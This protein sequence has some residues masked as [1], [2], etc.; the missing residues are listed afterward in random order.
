MKKLD[1]TGWLGILAC[2]VLLIGGTI[3]SGKQ[4]IAE[5]ERLAAAQA[6][7]DAEKAEKEAAIASDAPVPAAA[8]GD[9]AATP[10][11]TAAAQPAAVAA[12]EVQLSTEKF[13]LT[14]TNQGG[15]IKSAELLEHKRSLDSEGEYVSLNASRPAPV[16]ALSSEPEKLDTSLWSIKSQSDASVTFAADTPDGLHIEKTFSIPDH[17]R[18]Y[19]VDMDITIRNDSGNPIDID[20]SSA[21]YVYAGGAEPMEWNEWS[22]QMGLFIK[23]QKSQ[24]FK[25]TVDYFGGKGKVMGI[26]GHSYKPHAILPKKEVADNLI[27][28]GVNNQFFATIIEA[29]EPA[30]GQV[31][32]ADYKAT[33][34]GDETKSRQKKIR[35]CEL[36]VSLPEA[37]M[38]PGG[39][40]TISYSV[41]MGP[42]EEAILKDPK[43]VE[44]G[45]VMNYSAIPI[46]GKIFGWAISPLAKYLSKALVWIESWCHS[47]GL[48]IIILTILV[49]LLMWPV[50][51]KSARSMKRMSK[52]SPMLKDIRE[53]YPDDPQK[54]NQETMKLYSQYGIN[55]LGGCLPMFLQLPV[56][57]G[58]YRM[59]WGA[60][61]LRHQSFMG[62]VEDLTM[63]DQLAMLPGGLPL[64]ILPI[65]M[66]LASFIQMKIQPMTTTDKTQRMIFMMMPWMFLVFCYQFASGLALYWTISNIF[67]IVQTWVMNK[68]PEPEL[69]KPDPN[70]PKKKGMM[71]GFQERLQEKLEEAQAIADAKA[72]GKPV[73][74][75]KAP[76]KKKQQS[77]DP[78]PGQ[79]RTKIASE[80]GS[81]HT[82]AK[83]KKRR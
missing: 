29:K 20:K 78:Q 70:K 42:K 2:I 60:V 21:K 77:P 5:A 44:R 53:K 54:Q 39:Q 27:Y 49:R 15:G 24:Y 11:P 47:W 55:P 18:P 37:S 23:E 65:L 71:S 52:L 7:A 12:E 13:R 82:P 74:T 50:Y 10:A 35:G 40:R 8:A 73:P 6:E 9:T 57:L 28:A 19:E 58:F 41:Y 22:M 68:L 43:E 33:I 25:K 61:E 66:A 75:K 67:T 31:W 45:E 16:G 81:R 69:T 63:P 72:A 30:D 64:N 17:G 76:S 3:Y 34:H 80:K 56:F 48:A 51:A 79:S 62:F 14:L 1:L 46:F 59:L 4:R 38:N 26:F 36:A 32:A 83:K